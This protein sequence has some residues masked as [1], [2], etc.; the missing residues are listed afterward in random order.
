METE[1][2][3]GV[4]EKLTTI[5][6]ERGCLSPIEKA[7]LT[8]VAKGRPTPEIAKGMERSDK[9]V[10]RTLE[11]IAKKLGLSEANRIE[12]SIIGLREGLIDTN[13]IIDE[14]KL[15]NFTR[16]NLFQSQ[17]LETFLDPKNG[18]SVKASISAMG[19]GRSATEKQLEK[20]Y[21]QTECGNIVATAVHYAVF[22]E[23]FQPVVRRIETDRSFP[24]E[25]EWKRK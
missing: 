24:Y 2:P 25:I 16:L 21:Q 13:E 10:E 8:E 15:E 22:R 7:C 1:A 17:F 4:I 12:L 3:S 5:K 11:R 19:L 14:K 23:V 6:T 20:L 9:T 18:Y